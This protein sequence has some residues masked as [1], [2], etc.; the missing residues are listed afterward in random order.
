MLCRTAAS[1]LDPISEFPLGLRLRALSRAS[2][3]CLGARNN[4]GEAPNFTC[5]PHQKYRRSFFARAP[6]RSQFGGN[7]RR[8]LRLAFVSRLGSSKFWLRQ[9]VFEAYR[10]N[11]RKLLMRHLIVVLGRTLKHHDS[12]RLGLCLATA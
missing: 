10:K 4:R 9:P 2:S 1:E 7:F 3:G 5:S 11:P 12:R 6:S 8:I